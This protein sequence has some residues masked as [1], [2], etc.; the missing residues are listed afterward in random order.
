LFKLSL[1][2]HDKEWSKDFLRSTN[3]KEE[4]NQ[5]YPTIST[6]ENGKLKQPMLENQWA[7]DYLQNVPL[8]GGNY[9]L[10]QKIHN[11]W[12]NRLIRDQIIG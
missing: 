8:I 10:T 4:I 6:F 7:S 5:G 9:D 11:S 12:T 2:L 3:H 1:R